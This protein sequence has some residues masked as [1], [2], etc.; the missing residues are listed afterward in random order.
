MFAIDK[1]SPVTPSALITI[2]QTDMAKCD[3]IKCGGAEVFNK[4]WRDHSKKYPD[5][6][7][8]L[9]QFSFLPVDTKEADGLILLDIRRLKK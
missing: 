6:S 4:T 2:F 7:F 9:S 8:L 5:K 3:C 1:S